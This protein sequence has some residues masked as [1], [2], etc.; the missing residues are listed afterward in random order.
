M[1]SK[2]TVETFV[3]NGFS[4]VGVNQ[5][6]IPIESWGRYQKEFIKPKKLNCSDL[7]V[8][9][10]NI[11][12][13]LEL[14][15][16]DCKYD[17]TG[18]LY[19]RYIE[20]I[21]KVDGLYDKISIQKTRN[22][23]YHFWYRCDVIGGNQKLARRPTTDEERKV[24]VNET[25]KVLIETRGEGGYALVQPSKGYKFIKGS[26]SEI[27]KITKE[28]RDTLFAIAKEFDEELQQIEKPPKNT[29]IIDGITPWDDYDSRES[30]ETLLT[31]HGWTVVKESSKRIYLK[32]AGE[33]KA[34][35]SGNIL[36]EKELFMSWSSSTEFQPEK[37]YTPSGVFCI[38]EC[39]GDWSLAG[40]RLYEMGYGDRKKKEAVSDYGKKRLDNPQ[41]PKEIGNI[42]KYLV[43][44]QEDDKYIQMYKDGTIPTGRTTGSEKLDKSFVFKDG[45]FVIIIAHSNVGKTTGG[46]HLLMLDT[47]AHGKKGIFYVSENA[48]W[49]LKLQMMQWLMGIPIKSMNQMQYEFSKKWVNENFTF[50]KARGGKVTD[51]EHFIELI[52]KM[53]DEYDEF[54]YI[55]ADTYTAFIR[56][57]RYGENDHS[58]DE[59]ISTEFLNLTEATGKTL[60]LTQHTST[61]ARRAKDTDGFIKRPHMDDASGGGKWANRADSVLI[62]HRKTTAPAPMK[63]QT[64]IYNDK[65]R[66]KLFGGDVTEADD[67]IIMYW[68]DQANFLID[69]T[70]VMQN[71]VE[72][73]IKLG[74]LGSQGKQE[75]MPLSPNGDFEDVPF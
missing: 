18:E 49:E 40:R 75:S 66:N 70:N 46:A 63:Y 62:F 48:S 2:E 56:N 53:A 69:G 17:L 72:Q 4:V 42:S 19:D 60:Y 1:I 10:G 50:I 41:R 35:H 38:L 61:E 15:D 11:S 45:K 65:E 30:C 3:K 33:T 14:I 13:N 37:A 71:W 32:R 26:L 16:V 64:E 44:N 52:Y 29:F 68:Q 36:R 5:D 74:E 8:I 20:E 22:D 43:D 51:P 55:F 23:G 54:S 47:I 59:R 12:G 34:P 7:A 57:K 21:K 67:P 24:N 31:K 73:K 9:C 39:G 25:L 6:K 58:Y 27:K 28:E